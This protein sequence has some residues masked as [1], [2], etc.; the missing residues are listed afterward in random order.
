MSALPEELKGDDVC[1]SKELHEDEAGY[2]LSDGT[3]AFDDQSG[4]PL[5]PSLMKKARREEIAYFKSMG[6]YDK[7]PMDECWQETGQAPIGVRW[8]DINEGDEARPSYRLV[9]KEYRVDVKPG[10]YTATPPSECL[11][12]MICRLASARNLKL[13]YADVSSGI[14][15]LR[16]PVLCT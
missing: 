9:A 7:V 10:L 11:R 8:V 3:V 5:K 2:V 6:V 13:M 4:A 1:P 12:L 14:S 16:R 15:T